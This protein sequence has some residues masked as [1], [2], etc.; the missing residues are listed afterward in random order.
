MN[1]LIIPI[2]FMVLF[3]VGEALLLTVKS[4]Q[5]VDWHDV[6]FNINSGHMILWFF[7]GLE[8]VCYTAVL[9]TF[10]LDLFADI[11]PVW[12]WC[13]TLLA[14]D[15]GFYWLHRLHHE[16]RFLW[17]VHVVHHQGEH[18]NL[19]LGVRNSWYSSLTSIP[20][21]MYWPGWAFH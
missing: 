8:V 18:Y 13:F 2:I 20:F 1:E 17:A 9:N 12:T 4:K 14:W 10:S 3:V 21:F 11:S 19:S 5:R 16:W 15:L 7:R 6:T